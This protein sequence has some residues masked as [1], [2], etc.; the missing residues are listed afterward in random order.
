MKLVNLRYLRTKY[1]YSQTEIASRLGITRAA[2]TN[3]ESGTR[4]PGLK[5]LL[6][7]ADLYAVS[8]DELVGRTPKAEHASL[9]PIEHE[10]VEQYRQ[11]TPAGRLR[12]MN[13]MEFELALDRKEV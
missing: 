11:L 2:Y 1:G 7:L 9:L 13:Q 8:M 4:Q 10:V 3:Y 6:Q 5:V 12:V